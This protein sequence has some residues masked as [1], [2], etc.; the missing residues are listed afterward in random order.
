MTARKP[1]K[2]QPPPKPRKPRKTAVDL[3]S[4]GLPDRPNGQTAVDL[5]SAGLPDP[6]TL[7]DPPEYQPGASRAGNGRLASEVPPEMVTWLVTDLVPHATL[8]FVVGM[9]SS[10]KSTLGA[11]LCGLAKR[12][13]I[14]PGYEESVGSTMLPRLLANMVCLSQCRILD[15]TAWSLPNDRQRLTEVLRRHQ[16]DLLWIDPIDSYLSEEDCRGNE[17]VRAGL[18]GLAR[19]AREV[20]CAVVCSRHPGKSPGNLCPGYRAWKAVPREVL[21]IT[22]EVGPPERRFVRR[23]K[24]PWSLGRKP[25]EFHLGGEPRE[26]QRFSLGPEVEAAEADVLDV[27]DPIDR[28]MLEQAT[29]LLRE[30]LSRGK[31]D[32]VIVRGL[33]TDEGIKDGILRRAAKWCC[34]TTQ[35]VTARRR[36]KPCPG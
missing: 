16:S 20:P 13:A 5:G 15:D 1:K 23:T 34:C 21:E 17:G 12:P 8:I 27:V 6:P 30:V 10:G 28:T 18:E 24:D 19:L 31:V 14:L 35:A 22:H 2:P 26:P 32:S 4:A 25:R 29:D 33:A 9:P 3:G 36:S 7:P 11:W